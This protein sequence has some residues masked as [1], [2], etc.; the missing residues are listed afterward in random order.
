M[1]RR[2]RRLQILPI[3]D[4]LGGDGVDMPPQHGTFKRAARA[5]SGDGKA[6]GQSHQNH[7]ERFAKKIAEV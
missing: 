2:Y 7:N 4:M 6:P 5:R 1:R 3:R